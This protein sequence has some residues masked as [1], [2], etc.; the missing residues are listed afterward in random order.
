MLAK[1]S[2]EYSPRVNGHTR[3]LHYANDDPVACGQFLVELLERGYEIR[4]IRHEGLDLPR[5][6][7]DKMIK[8]AG[9]MLAS[10]SI[11]NSLGISPEEEHYRFGFAA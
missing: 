8:T 6:K 7:S 10:K 3:V 5:E 1:F 2:I 9:G 4:A 11:C